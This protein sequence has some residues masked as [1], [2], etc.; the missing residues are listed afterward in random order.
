MANGLR[1]LPAPALAFW[2]GV[3]LLAFLARAALLVLRFL[4]WAALLVRRFPAWAVLLVLRF[5]ASAFAGR[6]LLVLGGS[7]LAAVAAEAQAH[8]SSVADLACRH[9]RV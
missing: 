9:T 1:R 3:W 7:R 8:I 4:A 2:H 5:M 6:P